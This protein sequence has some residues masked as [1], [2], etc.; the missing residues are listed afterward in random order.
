MYALE[1]LWEGK[2]APSDRGFQKGSKYEALTEQAHGFM[3]S[4]RKEL[5]AEGKRAWE[6][7]EDLQAELAEISEQDTF[8]RGFRLGAR[9]ILDVIGEYASPMIQVNEMG[10]EE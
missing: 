8:I 7:Y 3:E 5:S 10:R 1:D 4:F 2:I 6:N 9:V